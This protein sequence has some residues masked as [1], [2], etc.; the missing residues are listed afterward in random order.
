MKHY[1]WMNDLFWVT[2]LKLEPKNTC[3]LYCAMTLHVKMWRAAGV[4]VYTLLPFEA[5]EG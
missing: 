3:R 4:S 1:A 2:Q 5:S